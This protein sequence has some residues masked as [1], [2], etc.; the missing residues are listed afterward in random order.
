MF[1]QL[2]ERNAHRIRWILTCGWF[3]LIFSLF[4]DPIS[5]ILT[6]PENRWSPF[7]LK[8]NTCVELQGACLDLEIYPLG[9]TIFWGVVIPSAIFI[10]LVFGHEAWRR[11]CPLA[12]ISQ[13]P[14]ALGRQRY[15]K[16]TKNSKPKPIRVAQESWLGRNYLYL[17]FAWLYLGLCVR[18][19]F[20]NSDRSALALWL[21]FTIGCAI[22]VGYLYGGKSWCHYF[23]PMAPVQ[24]V[25]AEPQ[26]L[27]TSKAHTTRQT[28]TQS[29]CRIVG[30]DGLEQT[31]CV[32][33]KAPCL[34]IDAERS[35]WESIKRPDHQ[36]LYYTYLGLV[37]GYFAYYY[38]YAGN[39]RYYFS[40]VWS[41]EEQQLATLLSPGFY[42]FDCPLPIPKLVAVP[43]TLGIFS[44]CGYRLGCWLENLYKVWQWRR[45][46]IVNL[47][48]VRHHLFTFCGFLAFNLLFLLGCRPL[49]SRQTLLFQHLFEAMIVFLSTLWLAL[50]WQ[51]SP[52]IYL[53]EKSTFRK[54]LPAKG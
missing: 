28:I 7:H 8:P 33:C 26:G 40:G 54:A 2:S 47:E 45:E 48:K 10:L 52:D 19:L 9:A 37:V 3:L 12:F 43:L 21:I 39:W 31:T 32:N 23:C 49:I 6:Y 15:Q 1:S 13:L 34:D 35:Y 50:R 14:A 38:L 51:R 42:I 25:F 16:G 11:I 27:L 36:W 22:V 5:P 30:K 46:S 4:C 20:V 18:I 17:Q 29:M 41:H 53:Q 24:K 44:W